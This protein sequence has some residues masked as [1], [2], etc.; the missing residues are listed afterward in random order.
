[1]RPAGPS[2]RVTMDRRV[3]PGNDEEREEALTA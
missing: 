2:R 1:M 3:K